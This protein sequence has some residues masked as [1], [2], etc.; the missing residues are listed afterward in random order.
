MV[1]IVH[2]E[3]FITNMANLKNEALSMINLVATVINNMKNS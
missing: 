2:F 1:L 3:I